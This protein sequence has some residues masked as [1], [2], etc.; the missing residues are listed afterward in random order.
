MMKMKKKQYEIK[1]EETQVIYVVHSLKFETYK[2]DKIIITYLEDEDL[3]VT[4][5]HIDEDHGE[6]VYYLANIKNLNE[7][8]LEKIGDNVLLYYKLTINSLVLSNEEP[9]P[10]KTITYL[11]MFDEDLQRIEKEIYIEDSQYED[12][13]E[14]INMM[15]QEVEVIDHQTKQLK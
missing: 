9:Q 7:T 11:Q 15:M 13:L 6:Y 5:I 14:L 2:Y 12:M 4:F 3:Q 8:D 1:Y 10:I